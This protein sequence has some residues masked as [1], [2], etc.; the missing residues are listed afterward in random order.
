MRRQIYVDKTLWPY[1]TVLVKGVRYSLSRLGF[2]LNVALLVIKTVLNLALSRDSRIAR[3]ATAYI[4]DTNVN[5][6]VASAHEVKEH[7]E[8]F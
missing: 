5:D 6:N 2:G 3:A 4:D 8:R 7:L 1:Q